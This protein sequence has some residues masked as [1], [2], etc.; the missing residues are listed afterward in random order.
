MS[1]VQLAWD[2]V[3]L[4]DVGEPLLTP[5]DGYV[6]YEK[7]AMGNFNQVDGGTGNATSHTLTNVSPGSHE[8]GVAVFNSNTTG[9]IASAVVNVPT[10]IPAAPGNVQANV[11]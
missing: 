9:A 2:L 1:D 3:T 5:V 8:F 10:N 7:D 11:V 4:D 6:I